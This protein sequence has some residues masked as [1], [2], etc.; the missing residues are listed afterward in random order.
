MLAGAFNEGAELK[1]AGARDCYVRQ[2]FD[3]KNP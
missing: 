3:R 2:C 1:L